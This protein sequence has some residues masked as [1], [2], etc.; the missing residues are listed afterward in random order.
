VA[1]DATDRPA[2]EGEEKTRPAMRGTREGPGKI[3]SG[4][5]TG[6]DSV[7][8]HVLEMKKHHTQLLNAFYMTLLS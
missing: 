6:H 3:P 5:K 4:G 7:Q 8:P 1:R 2:K